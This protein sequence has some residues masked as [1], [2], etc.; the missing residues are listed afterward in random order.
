LRSFNLHM[1]VPTKKSV[2]IETVEVAKPLRVGCQSHV[3]H[4][5]FPAFLSASLLP[6]SGSSA[7]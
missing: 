2:L 3:Y 7:S 5:C 6:N 1:I 4:F